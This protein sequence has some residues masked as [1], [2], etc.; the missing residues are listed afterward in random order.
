M[1]IAKEDGGQRSIYVRDNDERWKVMSG[2][3][4]GDVTRGQSVEGLRVPVVQ[5]ALEH[6]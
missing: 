4:Q 2:Y 1:D 5:H 6:R 3:A